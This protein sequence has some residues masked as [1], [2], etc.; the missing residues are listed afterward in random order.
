MRTSPK[1]A[2]SSNRKAAPAK[3]A[4]KA[5]VPDA[6]KMLTAEH[7]EVKALFEEYDALVESD[8]E[9]ADKQALAQEICTRLT[10]HATVEEEIFYPRAR[11]VLGGHEDLIDE[12][13][14]E[15]TTAKGLI[16]QI[17]QSNP[18]EELYD[19]KIKVLGEYIDHH[20]QEE[21]GEI[22]PKIK[23]GGLDIDSLGAE[24]ADRKLELLDELGVSGSSAPVNPH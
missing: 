17:E 23:K 14:V 24:M 21:E 5:A 15:H 4:S 1:A 6:I 3:A 9:A 22:F 19:A 8:G 16:A 20:V 11:E 7:K 13:D 18:D 12:A 10:V 2:K